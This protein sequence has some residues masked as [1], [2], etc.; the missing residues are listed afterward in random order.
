MKRALFVL[1]AIVAALAISVPASSGSAA[2][3]SAR[4]GCGA[5]S[6][7]SHPWSQFL[8]GQEGATGAGWL[9]F[10]QGHGGSCKVSRAKARAIIDNGAVP[11]KL[12]H[13]CDSEKVQTPG[14]WIE[15]FHTL[16]CHV[17]GPK[18]ANYS[19][20]AFVNPLSAIPVP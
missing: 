6:V 13:D 19:F 20:Q 11:H 1:A 2:H 18:K 3:S 12:K 10:W 4:Q 15:P 16:T 7:P 8:N 17:T 14:N 9:L 5:F